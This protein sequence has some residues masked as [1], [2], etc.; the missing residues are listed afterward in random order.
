MKIN[1]NEFSLHIKETLERM[2]PDLISEIND[3]K[4]LST[5]L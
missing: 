3:F 1:H 4:S 2:V 5:D